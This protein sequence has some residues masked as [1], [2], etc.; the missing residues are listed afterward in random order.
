MNLLY[1]GLQHRL[2]LVIIERKK[3]HWLRLSA[4]GE[5]EYQ[6]QDLSK[7]TYAEAL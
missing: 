5:S 1:E 2:T 7:T 6:E 4:K 3:T